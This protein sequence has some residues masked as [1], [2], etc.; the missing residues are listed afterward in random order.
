MFTD[1][2]ASADYDATVCLPYIVYF[3]PAFDHRRR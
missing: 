3:Y 1:D 2:S